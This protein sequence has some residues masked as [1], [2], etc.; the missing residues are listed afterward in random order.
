MNVPEIIKGIGCTDPKDWASPKRLEYEP[1]RLLPTDVMIKVEY[2]GVCGSDY[3]TITGNWGPYPSDKC[4]VGHEMVGKVIKTGDQVTE[5]KIGDYVGI[6]ADSSSCHEC[7]MCKSNN[8]QYCLKGIGTYNGIDYHADNYVTKGGYAS[9]AIASISHIFPIPDHL[10][11]EVAG[12]LL[13]GGL[14]AFSPL[15]RA[16][17]GN[18]TGKLVGIIGI[19][20]IGHMAVKF[21][22]A[23]GAT[24]VAFSRSS[25]KRQE[26]L[27]M[28]AD[29][30]IATGEEPDWNQRYIKE[31]DF[32]LNCASDLSDIKFEQYLPAIAVGGEF[33]MVSAPPIK[34]SISF[35]P[36][37]FLA[38]NTTLKGSSIGSKQE[39]LIML[40]LAAD[41]KIYPIIEKL[42]INEANVGK[43]FERVGKSDVR[44]K[45]VLTDFDKCF[46]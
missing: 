5:V 28:G 21:A 23:L 29:E 9:H 6:G 42:P 7:K 26:V 20:G 39:A 24:V 2:C 25:K 4:V 44:Y 22:K 38:N 43:A 10:P 46:Q 33:I 32:I 16:L 12:P 41:N 30:Y 11:R 19:G 3:H 17:Q 27:D 37:L 35:H 40:K 1:K 13:C 36:F 8:E 18:G 15:Y 14:T 31:F 45:F 34:Q